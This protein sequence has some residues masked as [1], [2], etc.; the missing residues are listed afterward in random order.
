MRDFISFVAG[1]IV[2]WIGPSVLWHAFYLTVIVLIL[3]GK[4][5]SR[6]PCG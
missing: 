3:A 6:L 1:L 4:I 2:G 5:Y